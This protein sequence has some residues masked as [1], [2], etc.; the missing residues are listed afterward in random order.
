[1]PEEKPRVLI[2]EAR[3]HEAVADALMKG[4]LDAIE[5][6]G[7]EHD[8]VIAPGVME[9]PAVVAMAEESGHRAAGV[10]FDGYVALGA[11]IGDHSYQFAVLANESARTLMDLAIGRRLAMG[12]GIVTVD[13][14]DEAMA[15]ARPDLGDRGGAAARACLEMIAIRRRF[16]GQPR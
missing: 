6:F 7:A 10:R 8:V 3:Q 2:V 5:A 14:E 13:D 11:V 15:E 1:M 4:A 9:I 16:L 12:Y